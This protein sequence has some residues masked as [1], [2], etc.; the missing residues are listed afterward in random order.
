[1]QEDALFLSMFNTAKESSMS[2]TFPPGTSENGPDNSGRPSFP[3]KHYS[4]SLSASRHSSAESLRADLNNMKSDLDTLITRAASLSERELSEAYARMMT[5]FGSIRYA[6]KGMAAEAGRQLNQGVD[7][8]SDY[9]KSKPLQ[10]V[11]LAAGAGLVLG[12]IVA[13][14]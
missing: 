7:L 11:A 8:T 3:G 10:S 13:R 5:K 6:A 1:L 14:R 2:A 9:V 4:D 12:M